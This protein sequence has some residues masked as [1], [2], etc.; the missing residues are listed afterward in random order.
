MRLAVTVISRWRRSVE[1]TR[2]PVCWKLGSLE[3]KKRSLSSRGFGVI[4]VMKARTMCWCG[5]SE[6]VRQRAG[7][8]FRV[9]KSSNGNGTRTTLPLDIE[10]LPI[11]Y[12]I[13]ILGRVVEEI[14]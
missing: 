5:P 3:F 8:S 7:R 13:D 14:E 4:L 12:G 1:E 2:S 11:L 10:G 9:D 6:S